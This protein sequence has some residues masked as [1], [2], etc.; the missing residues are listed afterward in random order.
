MKSAKMRAKE[1][2]LRCFL[3]QVAENKRPDLGQHQLASDGSQ[4]RPPFPALSK[5]PRVDRLGDS[6]IILLL[7]LNV[8]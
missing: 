2:M 3:L 7:F 5:L 6:F 1:I 8:G 4:R